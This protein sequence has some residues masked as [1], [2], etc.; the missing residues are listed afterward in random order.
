M[1]REKRVLPGYLE[2]MLETSNRTSND[3][4]NPKPYTL[5]YDC[6]RTLIFWGLWLPD[7]SSAG[8]QDK[9]LS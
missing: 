6:Y 2:G 3:A 7:P 4:L 9:S 1:K 8:R 5:N